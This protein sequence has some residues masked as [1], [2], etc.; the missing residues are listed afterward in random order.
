MNNHRENV[1]LEI[2]KFLKDINVNDFTCLELGAGTST[3][4][5]NKFIEKGAKEW[6]RTDSEYGIFMENLPYP[7]K[8]FDLI[9]SC[10]AFEHCRHP[11][12]ALFEMKRVAKKF[13]I[14]T[15]PNHCEHQVLKADFDHI[16]CLTEMQMKRLFN[17]LRIPEYGI[18]TQTE[19]IAKEQDWNLISIGDLR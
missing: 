12:I 8:S 3:E 5:E 6:I 11:L 13:I 9:F 15:T 14:I 1:M 4:F 16:F 19:N 2:E 17:Y 10:H 18:Y 7:D